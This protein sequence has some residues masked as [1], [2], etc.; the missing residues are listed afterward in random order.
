MADAAGAFSALQTVYRWFRRF[1]R[2]LLFRTVHDL[3]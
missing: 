1:V 3:V 2:P